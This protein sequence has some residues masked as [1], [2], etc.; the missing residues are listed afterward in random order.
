MGPRAR[1]RRVLVVTLST[2]AL[3]A[4]VGANAGSAQQ[5]GAGDLAA[6]AG[7]AGGDSVVSGTHHAHVTVTGADVAGPA[8]NAAGVPAKDAGAGV[9]APA[10]KQ[11]PAAAGAPAGAGPNLLDDLISAASGESNGTI[12]SVLDKALAKEFEAESKTAQSNEGKTFNKT[13]ASEEVRAVCVCGQQGV[14]GVTHPARQQ[15]GL[16][17]K[18]CPPHTRARWR[19][20][21][22]VACCRPRWRRW[23]ASARAASRR[24]TR[25]RQQRAL[26]PRA[27]PPV[28]AV[29]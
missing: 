14:G 15:R 12:A 22:G 7:G 9:A 1:I 5:A 3:A 27:G 23:C 20:L 2:L 4:V 10:A 16:K 8:V 25:T 29:G 11:P 13:V 28:A 19:L 6:A 24:E 21:R 26:W 17:P 18:R